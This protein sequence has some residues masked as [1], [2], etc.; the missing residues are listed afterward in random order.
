MSKPSAILSNRIIIKPITTEF[1]THVKASTTYKIVDEFKSKI[2]KYEI[3][4]LIK[5][6]KI[7]PQ[8]SLALPIGR[9]DLLGDFYEIIDSRTLNPVTFPNTKISLRSSQQEVYEDVVDNCIINAPVSWGKTFTALHIAKKLGQKT[10]VVTHTTILRAQWEQEVRKLFNI[11]PGVIGGG[12][13]E[14]MDSPIVVS[15]TQT[16]IKYIDQFTDTFGTVF[17]DEAHHT[18]STTFSEILGK[19]RARYKIGLTGT[20]L[21]KDGQHVVFRDYFSDKIYRP[22]IEN[23]LPPRI[24]LVNTDIKIPPAAHWAHRVTELCNIES[25]REFIAKLASIMSQK[26]HKVLVIGER[27][28]FLESITRRCSEYGAV[29]ITGD[30]NKQEDRAAM[31]EDISSGKATILCGSR[32]IFSEGVSLNELSCLILACPIANEINLTQLI[33]RIQ[34]VCPGKKEPIVIDPQ[35][36]DHSSKKQAK[37]RME[38]YSR[39]GYKVYLLNKF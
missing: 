1:A 14:N 18:P 37:V 21:R 16:L 29:C 23:S 8:G 32:N 17:I 20:L 39:M 7:L 25:Y 19:L 13:L 26:G 30:T 35:L 4:K 10:L 6:H 22:E 36:A 5:T 24:V 28:E 33:G 11:E 34:R 27:V 2:S 9:L 3:A 31:M 12:K 38:Y 15:N